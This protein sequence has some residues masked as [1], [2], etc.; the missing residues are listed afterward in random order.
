MRLIFSFL[1]T[2]AV[3]LAL[4]ASAQGEWGARLLLWQQAGRAGIFPDAPVGIAASSA[5]APAVVIL[6]CIL[7]CIGFVLIGLFQR[8]RLL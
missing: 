5:P 6:G 8:R 1:V 7:G 2:M 3:L 4:L